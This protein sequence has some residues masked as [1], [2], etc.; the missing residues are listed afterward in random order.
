[1]WNGSIIRQGQRLKL[2]IK[3]NGKWVQVKTPFRVGQEEQARALLKRTRELLLAGV[4]AGVSPAGNVSEYALGVWMDGRR[5]RVASWADDLS[6]LNTHILPA[7]GALPLAEVRPRHIAAMIAQVREGDA[8]SRTVRNIY[9][10]ARAL[11]RDAMIAGL[12]DSQPCIL[13]HHQ[14][15]KIRDAHH[16]WRAQAKFSADELR[17]LISD[18][19]VPQDRRVLYALMGLGCM[20]PG[21]AASLRWRHL[22]PASPLS[23]LVIANSNET[24]TTKTGVERA[25]PVHP[26][27]AKVLAEWKLSGWAREFERAPKPDDLIVPY[28]RPTNRG[29]RVKFGAMRSDHHTYKRML[30]DLRALGW[31]ARRV[32]DL[33]RTGITLYREA[34]A[35]KDRLRRCTH[36]GKGD[37]MEQYTSF[38]W[39]TLCGEVRLLSF[40]M[41][42]PKKAAES[43]QK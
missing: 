5:A 29:P 4:A 1:M 35:D 3:R 27:L 33:R 9:A 22:V 25:M 36:G 16:E 20:R 6:R 21:E 38:E 40:L 24:Q 34:G 26:A 23:R 14:L 43:Q 30:A 41:R 11:F 8:A 28:T 2:A 7:I 10:V 42:A 19:R 18:A 32:Y 37:V 12:C 39:V 13:T 15:G 31:R 17:T